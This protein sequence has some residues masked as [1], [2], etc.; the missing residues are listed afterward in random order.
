MLLPFKKLGVIIVDEE[1]D[2]SYKQDERVIYNARDMAI[3]RASFEK[4]PIHLITSVPS[5]E[6]FNNIQ[7]KKYRHVK[8]SKRFEDFPLPKTKIINLNIDKI[9]N[10]F[11]AKETILLVEE[12]LKKKEQVLFFINRRGF[13]PY[14]I[15]K[16]C[17]Y[18][19]SCSNCSL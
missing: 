5:V 6:T 15:C 16:K 11:I 9:K 4:I 8:I 12:Y 14:L 17:S 7:N 3:S 13:A 1:H 2:T 10:K 19:L 18:K